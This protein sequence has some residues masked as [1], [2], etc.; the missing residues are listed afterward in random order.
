MKWWKAIV[1]FILDSIEAMKEDDDDR[2]KR[3]VKHLYWLHLFPR[4]P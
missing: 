2:R 4:P 3:A 1:K